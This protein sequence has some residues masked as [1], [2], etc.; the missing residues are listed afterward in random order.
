MHSTPKNNLIT[1]R[2]LKVYYETSEGEK[3]RA[4][5]GISLVINEGE[6]LAVVGE[7]GSGKSTA[8]LSILRLGEFENA[9]I[10]DG[11]IRFLGEDILKLSEKRI[12]GIRGKE[13][14]MIFQDPQSS[15][16]P[17]MKIGSQIV[18]QL[19]V[20]TSYSKMKA[21]EKAIELLKKVG[22]LYPEP[23]KMFDRYPHQFSG[24]MI[25]R[26]MIAMALSC[27]PRL[28]IA[29]EPTSGL[30]VT[31][32]AQILDIFRRLKEEG[33][34]ILFVTHDLGIVSE[35]ADKVVVMYAGKIMESGS[36]NEV[37][38]DPLHPYTKGLIGCY[39]S[40]TDIERNKL[41]G[42]E[43]DLK[44]GQISDILLT[45]IPGEMPD[46]RNPPS[47]C[48]FHLRCI[49][50]MDRCLK[51]EPSEVVFSSGR[52]V[53]C[54]LF[55]EKNSGN[56][57]EDKGMEFGGIGEPGQTHLGENDIEGKERVRGSPGEF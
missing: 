44:K 21:K 47:G 50:R 53:F 26:A 30:D 29:D 13:I 56:R 14:A 20:H 25:Q 1:I 49:F 55:S 46:L 6:C 51:E 16:N 31:I 15:L 11:E 45:H 33:M 39:I 19:L 48:L 34:G 22:I 8:A 9:N 27:S 18:E 40:V 12:R 42:Q 41:I 10:V 4:V 32:Q 37:L 28:I 36:V 35:I 17:V 7:S 5:D 2:D 24:G 23:E 57:T 54:H 38:E 3:V 52:K 43:K